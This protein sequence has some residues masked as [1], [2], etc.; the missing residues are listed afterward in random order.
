MLRKGSSFEFLQQSSTW[1][2]QLVLQAELASCPHGTPL[3]QPGAS[4]EQEDKS[5]TVPGEQGWGS[6]GGSVSPS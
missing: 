3:L 1:A 4:W 2:L 5:G 6:A